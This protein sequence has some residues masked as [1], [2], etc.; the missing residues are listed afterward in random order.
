[1]TPATRELKKH[2]GRTLFN[3][4]IHFLDNG[5][6]DTAFECLIKIQGM[7]A[8]FDQLD[9][10][11]CAYAT[12]AESAFMTYAHSHAISPFMHS[13]RMEASVQ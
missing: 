7:K 4:A 13:V 11:L 8:A 1:M 12:L 5:D 10:T 9:S 2:Q 3:V 6:R